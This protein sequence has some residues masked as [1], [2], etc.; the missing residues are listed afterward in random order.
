MKEAGKGISAVIATIM[1]LMITVSFAGMF[2]AFSLGMAGD[3]VSSA[4]EQA[5]KTTSG[6]SGLIRINNIHGNNKP[7]A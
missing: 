2:Y 3:G 5:A 7:L 6:M 4:S 1:L